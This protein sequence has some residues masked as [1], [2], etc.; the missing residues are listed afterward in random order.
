MK[1]RVEDSCMP[2]RPVT[3]C[4]VIPF[5]SRGR[6]KEELLHEAKSA[7]D[8]LAFAIATPFGVTAAETM[9]R[10]Q[11]VLAYADQAVWLAHQ[12]KDL[13]DLPKVG[14]V[15]H[16]LNRRLQALEEMLRRAERGP[17]CA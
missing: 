3:D 14:L 2:P 9:L 16:E 7:A 6:A 11:I 17:D 15:L 4:T 12:N 5:R 8:C 1:Y 13:R 10:L